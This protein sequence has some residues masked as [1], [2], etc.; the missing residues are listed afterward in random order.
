MFALVLIQFVILYFVG[1]FF[2]N[3]KF[4]YGLKWN[5]SLFPLPFAPQAQGMY[6]YIPCVHLLWSISKNYLV[7]FVFWW[8]W[9]ILSGLSNEE[10]LL[11][12]SKYISKNYIC[13]PFIKQWLFFP[14]WC[15]S[16][17]AAEQFVLLKW[18]ILSKLSRCSF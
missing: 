16:W 2:F 7:E 1:L 15:L 5:R 14:P 6:F 8:S 12:H 13:F 9:K 18:A 3:L 4:I 10:V 17:A 11:E